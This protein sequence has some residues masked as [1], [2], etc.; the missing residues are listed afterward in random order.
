MNPGIYAAIDA[1]INRSI[2]GI[3]VCEDIFRFSIKNIISAE[4]KNLRHKIT[5]V[6]SSIPSSSL[7]AARDISKDEQKFVN[8][9]SEMMREGAADIFRSNI[10]RAIEAS[11][12]IEEFSKSINSDIANG[13][14]EIRFSLYDLEKRGWDIIEKNSL[15]QRFRFSLY[16]IIDSGFVPVHQMEETARILSTSGAEIIQL[17]MKNV[18]DRDFLSIASKISNIC[19]D[20]N[21]IFIVN[22]RVDIAMLS[23]AHGVHFGQDDIPVAMARSISGNGLVTGISTINAD[24]AL[25]GYDAD[26]IAVGPVFST[27][28][29]DGSMLDGIG[30]DIVREICSK[31]DKPVV[32]IGGITET[33]AG[34]LMEVGVS[35]LC[36]ISALLKDGK[37]SENTKRLESIIKSYRVTE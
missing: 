11:R 3:R 16:A 37:I 35:S 2:E 20:N 12:V 4:F 32:A 36:V 8:T 26:Y 15:M 5:A 13:F 29:K 31:T 17:R 9:S 33:N 34:A 1:N 21:T 30:I 6:I 28:S 22:D 10:R 24:E 14:Q 19:R 27:S 23:C 25:A 7:L 18:K